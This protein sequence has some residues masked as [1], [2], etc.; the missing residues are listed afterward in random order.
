MVSLSPQ[1]TAIILLRFSVWTPF[2]LFF[3]AAAV[4]CKRLSSW[5]PF[6]FV[7]KWRISARR[8]V[9]SARKSCGRYAP[10]AILLVSPN[11]LEDWRNCLMWHIRDTALL[12]S[13]SCFLEL[14][15]GLCGE[16]FCPGYLA[17]NWSQ[18]KTHSMTGLL[19]P[20]WVLFG[21]SGCLP[22]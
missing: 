2:A 13:G 22:H 17:I 9:P 5:R 1:L 8:T 18:R 19:S 7:Y 16:L 14:C 21:W 20:W 15:I 4:F 11:Q 10:V 6:K 12:E 3:L